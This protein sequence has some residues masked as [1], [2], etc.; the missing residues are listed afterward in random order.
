MVAVPHAVS[1]NVDCSV[2]AVE[3]VSHK[4]HAVCCDGGGSAHEGGCSV[5][6]VVEVPRAMSCKVDAVTMQWV[7]YPTR[8]MQ[9]V[10]TEDAVPMKVDALSLQ[11]LQCPV[12]CP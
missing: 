3:A 6:A 10:V 11:S 9:Y 12:H 5:F 2:E 8:W 7:Q 4:V 1:L